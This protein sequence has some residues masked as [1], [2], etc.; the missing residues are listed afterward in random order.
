MKRLALAGCV[1]ALL[2]TWAS[3]ASAETVPLGS[4]QDT[5]RWPSVF[6]TSEDLER[7]ESFVVT[8]TAEPIQALEF[9][10]YVS[11][12]RGSE[13]ISVQ[14]TPT[15]ITPPFTTTILPTLAEPDRCSID[16]SAE[17]SFETGLPGT[18]KIEV[19]GNHRPAPAPAPVVTPA[20]TPT[21]PAAPVVATPAPPTWKICAK[22]SFL[23]TG[24]TEALGETCAKSRL[25]VSAAWRK[26]VRAGHSV[27]AL[28][29]SCRRGNRGRRANIRCV[30]GSAIVK[31][32][33]RLRRAPPGTTRRDAG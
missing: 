33:G 18:V 28:G 14:S 16:A 31:A 19:T 4:R 15:T 29:F 1:A 9:Q 2:L 8:V 21:P 3:S 24:R 6:I 5:S 13:A 27:S 17:S 25:V 20:P 12:R 10:D 23:Q 7:A 30:K 26:P 22:P 32:T 11:C